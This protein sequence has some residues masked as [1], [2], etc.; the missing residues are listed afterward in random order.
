MRF[1]FSMT[2]ANNSC[3]A[4]CTR[5]RKTPAPRNVGP[6]RERYKLS[7]AKRKQIQRT[8]DIKIAFA[9]VAPRF[10]SSSS[11]ARRRV[12]HKSNSADRRA[13]GTRLHSHVTHSPQRLSTENHFGLIRRPI[14]F[15]AIVARNLADS[16]RVSRREN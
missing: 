12:A 1:T 13:T 16:L 10:V 14:S 3:D 9:S 2:H 8:L 5:Q 15:L 11:S 7:M 4:A 6:A